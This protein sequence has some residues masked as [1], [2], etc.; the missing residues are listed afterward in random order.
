MSYFVL[1]DYGVEEVF[2]SVQKAIDYTNNKKMEC[3][4]D[5]YRWVELPRVQ[6]NW[7]DRSLHVK[8]EGDRNRSKRGYGGYVGGQGPKDKK[9]NA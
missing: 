5:N 2:K 9:K 3:P 6:H 1:N 7:L 4:E 8:V